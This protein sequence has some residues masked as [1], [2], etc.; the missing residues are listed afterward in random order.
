MQLRIASPEDAL[1]L[2]EFYK[3]FPFRGPA[4]LKIER[5]G[6]YF[7]PYE[8]QSD[9]HITYLLE[10]K[11]QIFGTASFVFRELQHSGKVQQF[12]WGRDL[13]ISP[14]R[15]AVLEWT[16]H[17]LPVMTEIKKTFGCEHVFSIMSHYDTQA[18]NA[19]V[20]PRP[21]KRPLPRYYLYRRFNLV[22]LHGKFPWA[23][24]PL[25][26]LRIKHAQPHHY[27]QLAHYVISKSKE[28]DLSTVWNV[29]SF[30][31]KLQRWKNLRLE[32][33][34]IAVDAH[35]NIVGCCAPWS[36][37]NIEEFIPMD[38]NTRA[39][40][41]RQFLKFGEK[42]G[43]TRTLTKP[44][45]RLQREESLNFRYLNFLFANNADIFETL[46]WSAFHNVHDNEFLMYTQMRSELMF[47]RPYTWVST[48]MPFGIYLIQPPD[49]A[50]PEFIHPRNERAVEVEPF[51]AL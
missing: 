13:R 43:W 25:P 24:N 47:R 28:R 8:I 38:Y 36:S 32:D 51:W 21:S 42:L 19:F 34:L 49:L 31:D 48:K 3:E 30:Q 29:D 7:T 1:R 22:S 26:H 2:S 5:F 16:Q 45:H 27:D 50:P 15:K 39:H 12:A 35:D 18:L 20:R 17:Y 14:Q 9:K 23:S 44:S 10:N 37:A 6:N 46:L 41:F 4:E 33:F 11:S 40:N